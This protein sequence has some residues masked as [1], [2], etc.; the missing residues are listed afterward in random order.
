MGGGVQFGIRK[1]L[2][3]IKVLFRTNKPGL[4]GL[5]SELVT[6]SL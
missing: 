3:A 4:Q 1:K 5:M 2:L 6:H